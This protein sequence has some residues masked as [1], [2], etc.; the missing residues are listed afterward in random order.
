MFGNFYPNLSLS[1]E[2]QIATA[3]VA[4]DSTASLLP[5]LQMLY[6]STLVES[7]A[8]TRLAHDSDLNLNLPFASLRKDLDMSKLMLYKRLKTFDNLHSVEKKILNMPTHNYEH[9]MAKAKIESLREDCR[10]F[11]EIGRNELLRQEREQVENLPRILHEH[12]RLQEKRH[13][14]LGREI[15]ALLANLD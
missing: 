1:V 6:K 13:A 2:T 11:N 7:Q 3:S 15:Q 10:N 5:S 14:E 12:A 8:Q 4:A 9:A